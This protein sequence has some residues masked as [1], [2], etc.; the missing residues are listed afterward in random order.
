MP[1]LP[2]NHLG[3]VI[4]VSEGLVY[5]NAADWLYNAIDDVDGDVILASP[6]VSAEVSS[7]RKIRFRSTRGP[8]LQTDPRR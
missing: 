5:T 7:Q 3:A 6:Y 2:A 4:V 8:E 1:K